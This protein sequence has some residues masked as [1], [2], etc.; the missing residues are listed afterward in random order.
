[1]DFPVIVGQL[2]PYQPETVLG[3][4]QTQ[5]L[6]RGRWGGRVWNAVHLAEA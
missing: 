2:A 1:M 3:L 5:Q 4:P 6:G